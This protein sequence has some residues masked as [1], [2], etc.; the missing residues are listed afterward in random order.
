MLPATQTSALGP[1]PDVTLCSHPTAPLFIRSGDAFEEAPESIVIDLPDVHR[2]PIEYVELFQGCVDGATVYAREVVRWVVATRACEVVI[3]HNHPSGDAEPST[4][5]RVVTARMKQA[6]TL[7]EVKLMDHRRLLVFRT[8]TIRTVWA[9]ERALNPAR[10][11][12]RRAARSR[13]APCTRATRET[14]FAKRDPNVIA[15]TLRRLQRV[16]PALY[17]IDQTQQEHTAVARTRGFISRTFVHVDEHS[18]RRYA[19]ADSATARQLG[20]GIV[21]SNRHC[22]TD[23]EADALH[24]TFLREV[25]EVADEGC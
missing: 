25:W 14:V 7:I 24:E 23:E 8:L 16:S 18:A 10:N 20:G 3:A 1:E 5:D 12:A 21:F 2:S 11:R 17:T 13:G 6:L 22:A 9:N 15:R 4:A 19:P